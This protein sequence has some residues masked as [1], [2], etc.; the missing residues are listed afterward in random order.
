MISLLYL[1]RHGIAFPPGSPD[2]TETERPLTTKGAR[3]VEQ[4]A[5]GLRA[6]GCELD[7]IVSSPLARAWQTAEI[8]AKVLGR[9]D[10]LEPDDALRAGESAES[11]RSWLGQRP[12]SRLLIV[13]H[14]P[15][16]S[17]L[18]RLLVV[19]SAGPPICQL[20]KGGVAALASES[21][22]LYRIE[23]LARPRLLRKL[24]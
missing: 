4:V 14:E 10:Q 9:T 7:R 12:E 1:L 20:R 15:W 16:M 8:V 21:D 19:G 5:E 18:V 23:W 6:I 11:V 13:G 22:G 3:R 17:D 2:F 24:N